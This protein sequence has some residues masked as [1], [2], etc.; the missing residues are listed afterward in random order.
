MV[1]NI[2]LAGIMNMNLIEKLAKIE[3]VK[4]IK[5]TKTTHFEIMHIKDTLGDDFKVYSGCDE[6]AVSGL[7]AGADGII[8][9][10]YN[11]MPN[12]FNMIYSACQHNDYALAQKLQSHATKIILYSIRYPY[13]SVMRMGLSWMGVDAGYCRKPFEP[14]SNTDENNMRIWFKNVRDIDNIDD[15]EFLNYL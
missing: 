11:W 15:I 3:N 4:G 14:I 12:I 7:M 1:Y 8:G 5:Y 10:S 2:A 6:M 9:S 13:M